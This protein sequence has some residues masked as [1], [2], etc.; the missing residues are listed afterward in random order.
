LNTGVLDAFIVPANPMELSFNDSIK[1]KL[2]ATYD[3][4]IIQNTDYTKN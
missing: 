2:I 3:R 1:Q 4:D